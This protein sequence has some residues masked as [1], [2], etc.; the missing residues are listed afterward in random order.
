MDNKY[1]I[2]STICNKK[3]VARKI[4]DTLLEKKL[5]ASCHT[6]NINSKYWWNG[7]I[8]EETEILIDIR[9]KKE[10]FKEIEKEILKIHDYDTA[11]IT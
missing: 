3:E 5:A 9:T 1:C 11:E 8:E 2:V 10:L 6:S 7:K 4:V